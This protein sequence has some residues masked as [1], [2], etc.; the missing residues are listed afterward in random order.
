MHKIFTPVTYFDLQAIQSFM[1]CR[2]GKITAC[3]ENITNE[4]ISEPI[5]LFKSAESI[6][7]LA[8]HREF[9]IVGSSAQLSG[10]SVSSSGQ[11]QKKAWSIQLPISPELCEM[12]EVNDLWIDTENDMIYA[13][14]GDSNVYVCSLEDGIF[15]KKLSGHKDFIHSVHGQ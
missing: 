10:Y 15:V 1:F 13:G 12:G 7:S 11:I 3:I 14:C 2:I 8:F 6:Y 4:Q 5:Y 9:L